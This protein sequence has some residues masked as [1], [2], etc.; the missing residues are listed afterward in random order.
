MSVTVVSAPGELVSLAEAKVMLRVDHDA[1][2]ILIAQLIAAATNEAQRQAA[3]S[4]VTQT[5]SLALDRWPCDGVIRLWYP[6]VQ[7]VTSVKYYDEYNVLQTM[8]ATDYIA[9][10]DVTP[11]II[12]LA[13]DASWPTAALR[14]YS[15]IRVVYVAGYGAAAAV[16]I[17]YKFDVMGLVAVDYENR[18]SITSQAVAARENILAKLKSRWGWAG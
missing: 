14:L 10:T 15:P 8:P 13:R 1:D 2:N 5:L 9:I 7:S 12:I 17:D 11:A 18:E 3:R 16:P 4:F 6:P